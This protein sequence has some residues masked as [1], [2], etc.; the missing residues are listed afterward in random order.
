[1]EGNSAFIPFR[2]TTSTT[3]IQPLSRQ[4]GIVERQN[5]RSRFASFLSFEI[6][7]ESLWCAMWS[8]Q[9]FRIGNGDESAQVGGVVPSG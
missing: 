9:G 8:G 4:N 3:T 6:L 1:M 5:R 2:F 7:V